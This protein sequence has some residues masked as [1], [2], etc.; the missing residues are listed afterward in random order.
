MVNV[1]RTSCGC[2]IPQCETR[3]EARAPRSSQLASST[4]QVDDNGLHQY[5]VFGASPDALC[6]LDFVIRNTA[7]PLF[8][9]AAALWRVLYYQKRNYQAYLSHRKSK[10]AR[11][12]VLMPN[13]AL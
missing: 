3:N 6:H 11:L 9:A 2:H 5:Q 8:D 4:V 7:K 13:L 12:A 10:L 1:L